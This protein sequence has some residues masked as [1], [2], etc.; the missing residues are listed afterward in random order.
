M[1][2]KTKIITFSVVALF[3][4]IFAC[5]HFFCPKKVLSDM[6]SEDIQSAYILSD[7]V[8][9]DLNQ[10][11]IEYIIENLNKMTVY[12]PGKKAKV[13]GQVVYFD[14]T[15]KDMTNVNVVL[16]AT[17]NL[18]VLSGSNNLMDLNSSSY[19]V[20]AETAEVLMAFANDKFAK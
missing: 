12:Q 7:G 4:I 10:D 11:E 20:E 14:F 1:K 6:S 5:V 16:N 8:A 2:K 15:Y 19:R 3:A 17:N 13:D 18:V 9:I